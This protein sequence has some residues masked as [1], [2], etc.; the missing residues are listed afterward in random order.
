[1]RRRGY[2]YDHDYVGD[3]FSEHFITRNTMPKMSFDKVW[4][5]LKYSDY[6][7]SSLH[8]AIARHKIVESLLQ[9]RYVI[10]LNICICFDCQTKQ[11]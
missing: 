9:H 3:I 1:M 11:I 4:N 6:G 8:P 2:T 10:K 5:K 7:G